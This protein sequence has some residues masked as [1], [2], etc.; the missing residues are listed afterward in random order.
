MIVTETIL[1]H[2]AEVITAFSLEQIKRS[3]MYAEGDRTPFGV[4]LE[5]FIAP[6]LWDRMMDIASVSERKQGIVQFNQANR[7]RKRGLAVT[8]TKF[9]INFT[10]NFM[11]KVSCCQ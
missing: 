10:A 9:G 2:F 1:Q 11:N 3:N 5:S 6:T 7:W 8:A 4:T